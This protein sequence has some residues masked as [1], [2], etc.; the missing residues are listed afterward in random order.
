[1]TNE[2]FIKILDRN[3]YSYRMEGETLIVDNECQVELD[4]GKNAVESLPPGIR[5]ENG[6]NVLLGKLKELP[7]GVVFNNRHHAWINGITELP[8]DVQFLNSSVFIDG[9]KELPPNYEFKN[10]GVVYMKSLK[11]LESGIRFKNGHEVMIGDSTVLPL[12]DIDDVFQNNGPIYFGVRKK[13][14]FPNERWRR[15]RKRRVKTFESFRCDI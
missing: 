8:P 14:K 2:E 10:R 12:E 4:R 7:P 13:R 6:G 5:F 15:I 11:K 9:V 3:G 1:M